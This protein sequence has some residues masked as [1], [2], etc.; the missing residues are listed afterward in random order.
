MNT[1]KHFGTCGGCSYL[2]I[3]YPQE[4]AQKEANLRESLGPHGHLLE[5]LIPAP[6]QK[7]YRNKMEFA[8]GDESKD[9]RLAL[10]IRKRRSYY[11][12]ATLEDC[13]LIPEDFRKIA[14]H[15][16]N[17]FRDAGETFFH[18]KRHT[19]NLRHL[20]LRRGEFTGQVLICLSTT[21]KLEAA[22][23]PLI[24]QL[25]QLTLDGEIV[26]ILHSINDGVA[27]VVKDN[28][29]QI[30]YGK[31]RFQERLTIPSAHTCVLDFNVSAFSF[32]QTNSAGAQVLYGVVK[33]FAAQA[34]A[35]LPIQ[36]NVSTA[37][38]LPTK[39]N[40]GAGLA[41]DLYCGTGTIA[42][43]LSPNFTKVIGIELNP[44]A[45]EAAWEN[46]RL[47][48]ITNCEFF[49]GDV[50]E[51]LS[52]FRDEGITAAIPPLNGLARAENRERFNVFSATGE[53]DLKVNCYKTES[54]D[55][56]LQTVRPDVVVVDPPRNGLHPKALAKLIVLSPPNLVYVACKPESLARDMAALVE[57]RYK[58]LRIMGVDMFPRTPH[59][60]AV[61]LLRRVDK[62]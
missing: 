31:D 30:L 4:L 10:G 18:R 25:R 48:G 22:L 51:V 1:C 61:A 35:S 43:V 52:R 32:F 42:Q 55:S 41:Y 46:T 17:Y 34:G 44:S 40:S 45:I 59:V 38:S 28:N 37:A 16:Q 3:P 5:G 23:S 58:P 12:V 49:A 8:F 62:K 26:G 14:L 27:D 36:A 7:G 11:E 56:D 33:D 39:T 24:T 57:A 50:L 53:T 20:V 6:N 29:I 47:N 2:D 21:S 19:G 15:T 60:E 13:Q 54:A 9:G